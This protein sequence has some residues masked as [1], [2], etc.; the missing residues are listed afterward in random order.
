M[1]RYID[2]LVEGMNK[3]ILN[4]VQIDSCEG[5]KETGECSTTCQIFPQSVRGNGCGGGS[6]K[7]FHWYWSESA[8]DEGWYRLT[9]RRGSAEVMNNW[10]N[11]TSHTPGI[12]SAFVI[13]KRECMKKICGFVG[14]F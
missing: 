2:S 11:A 9:P 8:A 10:R 4:H 7:R 13:T 3:R 12:W 1:Q 5:Q 14:S 6:W